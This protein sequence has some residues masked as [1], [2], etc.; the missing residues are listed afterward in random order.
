M[1]RLE[2]ICLSWRVYKIDRLPGVNVQSVLES[3]S[4]FRTLEQKVEVWMIPMT[5]SAQEVFSVHTYDSSRS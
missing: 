4:C 3:T 1:H 2:A 5:D